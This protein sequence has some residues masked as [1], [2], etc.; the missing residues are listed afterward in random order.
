MNLKQLRERLKRGFF[1]DNLYEMVRLCRSL[2]LDTDNPT[3]FFVMQHIFFD[4]AMRWEDKPL[5]VEDAKFVE[6]EMTKPLDNL[7]SGIE[8]NLPGEQ[9]LNLLNKVISGYLFLFP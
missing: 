8:S 7:I 9:T 1:L 2:A 6:L 3:P 4:I 5:T